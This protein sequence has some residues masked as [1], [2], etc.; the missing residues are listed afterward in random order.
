MSAVRTCSGAAASTMTPSPMAAMTR[1]RRSASAL[2]S[3]AESAMG[4]RC[5]RGS[6]LGEDLRERLHVDPVED[7]LGDVRVARDERP[8]LGERLG[9]EDDETPGLV[10]QRPGDL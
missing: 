9:L 6:G 1:A 4:K 5:S 2:R 3:S 10:E 7:A 8:H